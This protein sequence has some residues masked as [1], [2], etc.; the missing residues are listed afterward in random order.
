[1]LSLF[2]QEHSGRFF[3]DESKSRL[4]GTTTLNGWTGSLDR[5]PV[6]TQY[7]MS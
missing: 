7:G 3:L 5:N 1:M 4:R 6:D 2:R